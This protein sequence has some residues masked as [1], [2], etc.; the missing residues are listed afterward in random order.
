MSPGEKALVV[1]HI[2]CEPVL[3][4]RR[5]E[6][7]SVDGYDSAGE[8]PPLAVGGA[9]PPSALSRAAGAWGVGAASRPRP[10]ALILGTA[11]TA[12]PAPSERARRSWKSC[13]VLPWALGFWEPGPASAVLYAWHPGLAERRGQWFT[14]TL[15]PG[16]W[17]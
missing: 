11:G 10:V 3:E 16:E 9:G 5:P 7:I 8:E 13:P 12:T 17:G 6:P 1:P 2:T 4:D 15:V 14:W